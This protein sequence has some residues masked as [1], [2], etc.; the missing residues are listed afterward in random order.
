[1]LKIGEAIFPRIFFYKYEVII[2]Q[3]CTQLVTYCVT[4]YDNVE[5]LSDSPFLI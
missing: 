1:M 4:H 5:N 3:R 2:T